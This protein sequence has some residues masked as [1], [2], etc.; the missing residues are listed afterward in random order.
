MP[1][2]NPLEYQSGV[3]N[4]GKHEI[5]YRKRV[6]GYGSGLI[7][8][9]LYTMFVFFDVPILLYPFILIPIFISVHGFN[10]SRHAFCTNYGR[11]GRYNMTSEVGLTQNVLSQTKRDKDRK[12]ASQLIRNSV[13]ISLLITA[14]LIGLSRAVN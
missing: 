2:K 11:S 4:I 8:F 3:C 9:A 1:E 10:E 7:S 13:Q 6:S 12:Y 14:V 5:E